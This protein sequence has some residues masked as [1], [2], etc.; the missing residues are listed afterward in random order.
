M[1]NIK[2]KK[3]LYTCLTL[4]YDYV[5]FDPKTCNLTVFH[6]TFLIDF[7]NYDSALPEV[8]KYLKGCDL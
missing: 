5:N 7:Y 2:N 4:Y 6:R 1:L 8:S 3:I